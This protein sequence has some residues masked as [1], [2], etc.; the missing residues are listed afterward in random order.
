[1]QVLKGALG[2]LV[3]VVPLLAEV[4]LSSTTVYTNCR[5]KEVESAMF[6]RKE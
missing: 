2:V 4:P 1:M 3:V 5:G 6:H